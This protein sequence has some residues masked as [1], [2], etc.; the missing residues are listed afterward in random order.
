MSETAIQPLGRDQLEPAFALATEVFIAGSNV[1][2]ALGIGLEAYRAYLRPS[3]EAM[4]AE[5]LS[6]AATDAA[7]G[8]LA[9]CVIVTDFSKTGTAPARRDPALAPLI[10]LTDALGSK[11]PRALGAGEAILVDM[12]CVAEGYTGRG[13]Y[14]ALRGAAQDHAA[15][16]GF[17]WALGELSSAATQHV[18]L[19]KMGHRALARVDFATFEFNGQRPFASITKPR[20]LVLSE[21]AL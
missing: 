15:R 13:L 19:G 16:R 1:H 18:I 6:F 21:G 11:Y 5:G 10:A 12:A 9:G 14:T 20:G 3:F 7:T 17:R 2:R 4:V 8:A